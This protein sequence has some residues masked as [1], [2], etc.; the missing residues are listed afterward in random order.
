MKNKNKI[1]RFSYTWNIANFEAFC[2]NISLSANLLFMKSVSGIAASWRRDFTTSDRFFINVAA[3][4]KSL[5]IFVPAE[6][7]YWILM[8]PFAPLV[9]Y[10]WTEI[11]LVRQF[12]WRTLD[13]TLCIWSNFVKKKRNWSASFLILRSFKKRRILNPTFFF[14]SFS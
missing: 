10:F 12:D 9:E 5:S 7:I 14:L 11:I 1:H 4:R 2:W 6:S 8:R 13:P 3:G